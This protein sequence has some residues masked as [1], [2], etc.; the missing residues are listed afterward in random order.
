[1]QCS[2]GPSSGN[3]LRHRRYPSRVVADAIDIRCQ[4][5]SAEA[6][7]P[8]DNIV[9]VKR[10]YFVYMTLNGVVQVPAFPL[11]SELFPRAPATPAS[12]SGSP[13]PRGT[14][15]Y[16]AAQVVESTENAMSPAY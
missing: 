12:R 4:R 9:V 6:L 3:R 15:P 11:F 2:D 5:I 14:A 13:S 1:M 10:V 16:V 8:T 7:D